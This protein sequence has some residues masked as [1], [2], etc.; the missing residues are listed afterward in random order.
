MNITLKEQ[1]FWDINVTVIY[2]EEKNARVWHDNWS[3]G[4]VGDVHGLTYIIL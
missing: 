3:L 2:E 4:K 1:T